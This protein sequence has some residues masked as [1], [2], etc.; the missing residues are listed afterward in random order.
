[1]AFRSPRPSASVSRTGPPLSPVSDRDLVARIRGGDEAAFEALFAEHYTTLCDFVRS[2]VGAPDVAEDVV[3]T[4]F[5]GVWA[6][7]QTWN[8][9]EGVRAY[10]FGACRN[11][12][13]DHLRHQHV[14]ARKAT[15]IAAAVHVEATER[16]EQPGAALEAADLHAHLSRAVRE[17]PERRRLVVILRWQHQLTNGEIARV[18]GI[19]EKGVETQFG[20]ALAA[21]R[22]RFARFTS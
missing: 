4:A 5:L 19:S 14:V 1:M 17:L 13:L 6:R 7:R 11:R 10:L 2:L 3:Q 15:Q 18:L 12:A 20:R 21:L 8:P 16:Q 9:A 22:K